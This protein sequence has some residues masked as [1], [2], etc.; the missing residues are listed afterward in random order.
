MTTF[1]MTIRN[2]RKPVN[3][4]KCAIE[5]CVEVFRT[6]EAVSTQV[7]YICKNHPRVQ[8]LRAANRVVDE[9]DFEDEDVHFQ[10]FSF[11]PFFGGD[12]NIESGDNQNG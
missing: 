9:S 10:E 4:I 12:K 6:T 1:L 7:R 3:E 5:G 11:D 8:Q 2:R